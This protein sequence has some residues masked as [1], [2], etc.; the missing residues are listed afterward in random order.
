M[1]ILPHYHIDTVLYESHNSIICRGYRKSDLNPVILKVLRKEYPN[2]KDL[3]AF[4]REYEICQKIKSSGV[5]SVL[6]LEKF[7]S[8]L[9]IVM[10]DNAARSLNLLLDEEGMGLEWSSFLTLAIKMTES[11]AD[12]HAANI[13]HKDINPSNIIWNPNTQELKIIDFGIACQFSRETPL[14][15]NPYK[16]EGTLAYIS[17]EQSGRMNSSLDCR[18]DIYSL[19]VTFYELLTDRLPFLAQTPMEMIHAHIARKADPVSSLNSLIPPILSNIIDK[20]MAKNIDER[21]QSALGIKADLEKC[22]DGQKSFSLGE[23]DFSGRFSIPNKLYGRGDEIAILLQAFERISHGSAEMMFVAGYSGVGKTALVHEVHKP[24]CKHNGN[25]AAGKFDQYQRN[26]P[27]YALS[28]AF[29]ELCLYLLTENSEQLSFW[30]NKI[31]DVVADN[32]QVLIDVIPQLKLIIGSQ[33]PVVEVGG[34]ESLNRFN[35]IFKSFFNVLCDKEHPLVLFI[36]DLQWADSAS[37]NLLKL[38]MANE[39]NQYFLIIGAYRDNEVD[40]T[41]PLMLMIEDLKQEQVQ[42]NQL[43]L[44]NLIPQDINHMLSDTFLDSHQLDNNKEKI[45][46]LTQLVYAKTQGNA[47]FTHSF[48]NS[49]YEQ[50]LINF[51]PKSGHWQWDIAAI[52]QLN[53]TDNVVQLLANKIEQ[54]SIETQLLLKLA[55]CIGNQF[56]LNTLVI[57]SKQTTESVLHNIQDAIEAELL[58]PLDENYKQLERLRKNQLNTSFRFQHDRIQQAAYWLIA[59]EEK[60][61][62]HWQIGRLL[63]AEQQG[64]EERLFEVVDHLNIALPSIEKETEKIDLAALNLKAAQHAKKAAAYHAAIKYLSCAQACLDSKQE[65]DIWQTNY[66]LILDILTEKAEAEYLNTHYQAAE[67]LIKVVLERANGLLEKV[68]VLDIQMQ[69][70]IAQNQMNAA[71]ESGLNVLNLL[72]IELAEQAPETLPMEAYYR[73]PE[74]VDPNKQAAMSILMTL[75]APSVIANPK[76]LAPIAFTMIELCVKYGNS[77]ASAFAY[78]FYGTLLCG[79]LDDIETGYE[80]GQLSIKVLEKFQARETQCRVDNLYNAF[81]VHWKEHPRVATEPLRNAVHIG[82]QTGDIQFACYNAVNYIF[83]LFLSGENLALINEKQQPYIN[84]IQSLRQEFQLYYG[85]IWAQLIH[86]LSGL[87]T[88]KFILNGEFF[89]ELELLPVLEKNKN[90]TSLFCSYLAKSILC[91]YFRDYPQAIHFADLAE[92]NESAMVGLL[93]VGQRPF[94]QSLALLKHYSMVSAE[95]QEQFLMRVERNQEKIL[96]WAEHGPKNYQHKYDLIESVKAA[97]TGEQLVAMRTFEKAIAAAEANDFLHETALCYELAA[98]FYLTCQMEKIGHLYIQEAYY[99]YKNW[100]AIAKLRDLE[101]Q[102]PNL[103]SQPEHVDESILNYQ[104]SNRTG[105]MPTIVQSSKILDLESVMKAS[106]TIVGEVILNRLLEKM[107]KIIIEN[108]GA[109]HAVLLLP[110]G[111]RWLVEAQASVDKEDVMV[112]CSL[113]MNGRVPQSIISYVIRSHEKVVLNNAHE[114]TKYTED[115]YIQQY[116]PRSLLCFPI[117]YQQQLRAI[118]YLENNLTSGAFKEEQLS[119]LQLLSSQVA[120][121]LENALLYQTLENKVEKRTEQLSRSVQDL[122]VA[123]KQLIESEKMASLGSLVAGLAHEL[124]TPLGTSYTAGTLLKE[125]IRKFQQY[126]QN[127]G[128]NRTAPV[129]LLSS[130]SES[131]EMTVDN[132]KRAVKLVKSFKLLAV[133]QSQEKKCIFALKNHLQNIIVNFCPLLE[134]SSHSVEILGDELLSINS[135]PGI[136]ILILN[137]LIS[138]TVIHA[139]RNGRAGKIIIRFRVQGENLIIQYEDKGKGMSAEVLEK[140]FEPFYTTNRAVGSVGLGLHIVYNLV[141]QNLKGKISATS[142][143]GNGAIFIMELPLEHEG[144]LS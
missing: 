53:I 141:T 57:I 127:D 72:Q 115:E 29:N 58:M 128:L 56:D 19:G 65:Y 99:R 69:M 30:K 23:N 59:E 10:K 50:H 131:C 139:Y 84:L 132:I 142:K 97:V 88:D 79:V 41:H 100:G 43:H 2:L 90:Y 28:Q 117:L 33:P 130:L 143:V 106:E 101:F 55:A 121:A 13:I 16:L 18:S 95:Q 36:D 68:K 93:P 83:T 104:H 108:A 77:R 67:K 133:D 9:I 54:Y 109:Q 37:L 140:I 14:L 105:M 138:N 125:Q 47:F 61:S 136:F 82:L 98:E 52:Y 22:L 103:F 32:G 45:Q 116:K 27:Y 122:K 76:L 89:N 78:G 1:F 119:T 112:L 24:M 25:F 124:N 144:Y 134:Q 3:N 34:Q 135:Y 70:Y 123:Q 85:K 44:D 91:Y 102:F 8:R 64:M 110:D 7:K 5:I 60:P 94:Y 6:A 126:Y 17:P 129:D 92:Q 20:M 107:L 40:A 12:V 71:I 80:F 26:I 118:L 35:L 81:I 51:S 96:A 42:I 113:A 49:L 62:V 66:Q 114:E 86:N 21:Y 31:L 38:L 63:L 39:N 48:I 87:S 4:Q 75:F 15:T 137:N 74:M 111:G 11:L 120:I 73:L 46:E